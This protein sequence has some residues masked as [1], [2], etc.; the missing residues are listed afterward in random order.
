M[1][2]ADSF[3]KM[4]ML[5]K[6]E[7]RRKRGRQR[8]KWLDGITDSMDMSL[9]KLQELLMDREAWCAA[10][11]GV[12]KSGTWL[13]DWIELNTLPV[14]MWLVLDQSYLTLQL[15][16][17]ARLLCS[18]N[19]PMLTQMEGSL[20]KPGLYL[21]SLM[22][23]LAVCSQSARSIWATSWKITKPFSYP[24]A[25][26]VDKIS[27]LLASSPPITSSS[28]PFNWTARATFQKHKSNHIVILPKIF[29]CA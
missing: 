11:H 6:I 23:W 4:L 16:G 18:W 22:S 19:F 29:Q 15:H 24:Y 9:S 10:V 26:T 2:R 7:G 3:E 21:W 28:N 17:P 27:S 25:Y 1:Q 20:Q 5:G 14:C 13:N 12:T 8:M